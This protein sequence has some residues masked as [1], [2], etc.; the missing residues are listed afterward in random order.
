M[1]KNHMHLGPNSGKANIEVG[2]TVFHSIKPS[3]N[4][5]IYKL[6]LYHSNQK[7]DVM[8]EIEKTDEENESPMAFPPVGY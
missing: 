7:D 5:A 3:F 4:D 8:P 6:T 1:K 2:R